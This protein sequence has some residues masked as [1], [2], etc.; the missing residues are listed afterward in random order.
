[1]V[2]GGYGGDVLQTVYLNGEDHVFFGVSLKNFQKGGELRVAYDYEWDEGE[3]SQITRKAG[4][5]MQRYETV[6]HYLLFVRQQLPENI[7]R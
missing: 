1:M 3:A 5:S 7:I 6:E 2:I 4:E